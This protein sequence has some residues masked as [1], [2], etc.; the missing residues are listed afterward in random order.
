[1]EW[2]KESIP[3]LL[4]IIGKSIQGRRIQKNIS[5]EELAHLSGVSHA[6]IT[7]LESGTGNI[8]LTNL[9][10]IFKALEI[11]DELKFIFSDPKDSPSIMAKRKKHS[12]KKRVRKSSQHSKNINNI[13]KWGED[14]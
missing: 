1:M 8:S 10:L 14:K 7:R 9:L 5:Q 12:T 4:D 2:N 6:S 11:A 13:W 3:H